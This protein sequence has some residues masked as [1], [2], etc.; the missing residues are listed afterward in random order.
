MRFKEYGW[1]AYGLIK[2]IIH[3][4]NDATKVIKYLNENTG[5][6]GIR[7][8]ANNKCYKKIDDTLKMSD[9]LL[10]GIENVIKNTDQ[11]QNVRDLE[12]AKNVSNGLQFRRPR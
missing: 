9:Q 1:R 4:G 10:S 5:N 11:I 3:Y 7:K 12:T 8:I 2:D 6:S